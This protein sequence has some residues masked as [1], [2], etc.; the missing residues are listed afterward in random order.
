MKYIHLNCLNEW[1]NVSQKRD[2]YFQCDH[3]RYKYR[4]G[5]TGLAK[6]IVNEAV[7]TLL[8]L[9]VFVVTTFFSGFL[10][11]VILL[12]VGGEAEYDLNSVPIEHRDFIFYIELML[13]PTSVWSIDFSHML[14]GLLGLG[15]AGSTSLFFSV[16][17]VC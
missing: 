12:Y 16:F 10:M 7:V 4:L 5:R 1:R 2:S 14:S 6:F 3:C 8:T 9:L 15:L 11:K 17:T 13:T